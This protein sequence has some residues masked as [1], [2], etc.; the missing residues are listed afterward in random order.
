MPDQVHQIG[1]VLAVMDGESGIKSDPIG[2]FAQKPGADT[3]KRACPGQRIGHG[4]GAVADDLPRDALNAPGHF[5]GGATRKGHQQYSTGIGTVDDQMSD[6]VSQSVGLSRTCAGDDEERRSRCGVVLT[7]TMLDSS[8]LFAVEAFKISNGHW[9]QIGQRRSRNSTTFLVLFANGS[10]TH[11]WALTVS[12]IPGAPHSRIG[13]NRYRHRSAGASI[14]PRG[15]TPVAVKR[16]AR[17]SWFSTIGDR[18]SNPSPSSSE[19]ISV[20][21]CGGGRSKARHSR[22]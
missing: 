4:P 14:G 11:A 9:W 20:V 2:I 21:N 8:S 7:H 18:G 5:G 13:S 3:M 12:A 19:S 22:R 10:V 16:D 6:P 15:V 1:R 17:V